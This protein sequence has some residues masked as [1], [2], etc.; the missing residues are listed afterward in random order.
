MLSKAFDP[1]QIHSVI[2]YGIFCM[3]FWALAICFFRWRRLRAWSAVSGDAILTDAV[4]ILRDYDGVSNLRRALVEENCDY[5]PLLRRLKLILEQWTLSPG[6]QEAEVVLG[7]QT[8]LDADASARGYTLVRVMVW[9]L[10][11]LGLIGTVLGIADAVGGFANFLGQ[12][13]TDVGD[14]RKKLVEVTGGLSFAFLI[15]L[16]G[17]LT[18]LIVMLI[19]SVEQNNEE[20]LFSR[21]LQGVSES[22]LPVLQAV[23][24][25]VAADT[26]TIDPSGRILEELRHIT[27][28]AV[29]AV[30]TAAEGLLGTMERTSQSVILGIGSAG[31]SAVQQ[32]EQTAG[33]VIKSVAQEHEAHNQ[34]VEA[35]FARIAAALTTLTQGLGTV[36][37]EAAAHLRNTGT[38]AIGE[39]GAA[40]RTITEMVGETAQSAIRTMGQEHATHRGDIE[41]MFGHVVASLSSLTAGLDATVVKQGTIVERALPAIDTLGQHVGQFNAGTA[42]LQSIL[43]RIEQMQADHSVADLR[44]AID[45]L[46]PVL[47]RFQQPFVLQAVP[48]PRG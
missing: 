15:T 37:A 28:A 42:V 1:N 31:Q 24:P 38:V 16:E 21:V 6:L 45:Q 4:T 5:S 26:A 46:I 34:Q 23:A 18:S 13:I 41:A 40:G 48:M 25:R 32:I 9:A 8:A 20:R 33:E 27:A 47:A 10:P 3:F 7:N 12:D 29:A 44:A 36:A 19:V 2:P 35:T 43:Q 14:I 22:F 17:L 39:I 11:V 30:R